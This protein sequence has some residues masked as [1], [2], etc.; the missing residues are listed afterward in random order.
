MGKEILLGLD[1]PQAVMGLAEAVQFGI[2]GIRKALLPELGD[3]RQRHVDVG[4]DQLLA[5][6]DLRK[7]ESS[8]RNHVQASD[9]GDQTSG[10]HALAHQVKGLLHVIRVAA[11]RADHVCGSVVD[12]VEIQRGLEV[13]AAGA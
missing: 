12:V 13:G 5:T 10:I 3:G 4:V 1:V 2:D 9:V 6:L 8:L 11:A 7:M